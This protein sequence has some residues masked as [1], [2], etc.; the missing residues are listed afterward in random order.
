MEGIRGRVAETYA[1]L[2]GKAWKRLEG[3]MAEERPAIVRMG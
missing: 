2:R 3:R 1:P